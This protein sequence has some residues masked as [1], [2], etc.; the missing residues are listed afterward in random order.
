MCLWIAQSRQTKVIAMRPTEDAYAQMQRAFDFYNERLFHGELKQCLIT[1]H[2]KP[3]CLGYFSPERFSGT[4]GSKSDEIALNIA[5][6]AVST[7][8][9][10][11]STLVHEQCHLKTHH[12]GTEGRRGYHNKAWADLMELIGLMPSSNGLPGG[13]RVGE[14]VGHYIIPGGSFELATKE[15]VGSGFTVS[16]YDRQVAIG[17]EANNFMAKK[18]KESGI[19]A[20]VSNIPAYEFEQELDLLL[21]VMVE[22]NSSSKKNIIEKKVKGKKEKNPFGLIKVADGVYLEPKPIEI[23]DGSKESS[24]EIYEKSLALLNAQETVRE[25]KSNRVKYNCSGCKSNV[26]GKPNLDIVCG[27][28]KVSFL[29]S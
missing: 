13:N 8:E 7:L 20:D 29:P 16:W 10:V 19:G 25:D 23:D 1:F 27:T 28:C 3:R 17:P 22:A 14:K 18:L 9:D 21:P 11:M 26:W 24:G 15:L 2:R 12:D 6:F 5:Y 4:N